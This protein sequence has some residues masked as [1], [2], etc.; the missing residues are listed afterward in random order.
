MNAVIG[1]AAIA[2]GDGDQSGASD[3]GDLQRMGAPVMH[4]AAAEGNMP[5]AASLPVEICY[6]LF[7]IVI[8]GPQ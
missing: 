2:A 3:M 1:E 5:A 4:M 7:A 6:I 8:A